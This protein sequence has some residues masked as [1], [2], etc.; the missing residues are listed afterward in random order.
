MATAAPFGYYVSSSYEHVLYICLLK[1]LFSII[2]DI[3]LR[4]ESLSH[5]IIPCLTFW[6]I[7]KLF[8]TV[9]EHF[10]LSPAMYDDSISP[11]P[12]ENCYFL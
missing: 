10:A 9:A 3:Y 6:G 12:W 11:Y 7:G 8:S 1:D 5:M 2:L 4:A